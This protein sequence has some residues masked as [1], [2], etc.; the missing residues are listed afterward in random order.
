LPVVA[1]VDMLL[2]DTMQAAAALVDIELLVDT[3]LLPEH[4][5]Q[6]L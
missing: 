3:P 1:V 4:R 2:L 6:S 5:F